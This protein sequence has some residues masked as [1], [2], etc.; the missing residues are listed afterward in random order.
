MAEHDAPA[1]RLG[2]LVEHGEDALRRRQPLLQL[3]VH[4]GQP[5]QRLQ[6]HEHCGDEGHE[7]ADGGL[8][9]GRL[10]G[11]D[12][13]DHGQSHGCD[14]L[15]DGGVGGGRGGV[16]HAEAPDP[17]R[18]FVEATRLLLRSAEDL[19]HL[20]AV[21]PLVQHLGDFSHRLLHLAADTAQAATE[22]AHDQ[23]DPRHR[24]EGDERELPV[25]VEQPAQQAGNRDAV[26][27][28]D[29]D[30]RG[31]G[32]GDLRDVEGDL[33]H[34][35][36][37]HLLVVELDRQNH[38]LP[39]HRLAQVSHHAGRDPVRTVALDEVGGTADQEQGHQRHR[40]PAHEPRV[41]VDEGAVEQRLHERGKRRLRESRRDG[42]GNGGGENAPVGADVA[43]KTQI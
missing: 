1:V 4:P 27:E 42:A 30:R 6:Q 8:V 13:D 25:Q 28:R 19:D 40:H 41:L 12:G 26:L 9:G 32:R 15:D 17:V 14:Q 3:L 18:A 39:E 22:Q 29:G 21:D 16:L 37:A 33:G 36:A 43:Q 35:I 20:L 38:E 11:D 23:G 7:A 10:P 24:D 34:Q 5:L 2:G 31:R